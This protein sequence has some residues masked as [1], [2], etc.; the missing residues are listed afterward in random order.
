MSQ[1]QESEG[2]LYTQCLVQAVPAACEVRLLNRLKK[3]QKNLQWCDRAWLNIR[4][5][6][7]CC[8]KFIKT[9][10]RMSLQAG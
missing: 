1:L 6:M 2:A 9:E 10:A 7:Q 8:L 3:L 5:G 4:S